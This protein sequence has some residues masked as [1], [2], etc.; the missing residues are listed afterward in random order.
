MNFLHRLLASAGLAALITPQV[1]DAA[2]ESR[3]AQSAVHP[4]VSDS[5]PDAAQRLDPALVDGIV[6]GAL[7]GRQPDARLMAGLLPAIV[8]EVAASAPP[9]TPPEQIAGQL[10]RRIGSL[11]P[12]LDVAAR[13]NLASDIVAGIQQVFA[14]RGRPVDR[15]ALASA[16]LAGISGAAGAPDT[17]LAR[18][19][20]ATRSAAL[21]RSERDVSDHEGSRNSAY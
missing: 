13:A 10:A 5:Y 6:A 19:T 2:A 15:V 16:A 11:L 7:A 18:H 4:G 8:A 1:A 9:G 12:G 20:A 14:G 3:S 21:G 17:T